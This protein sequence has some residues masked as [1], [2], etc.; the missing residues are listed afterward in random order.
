MNL[1]NI[2]ISS[3]EP[4]QTNALW[5]DA[6]GENNS[7]K[8]YNNG[9][10]TDVSGALFYANADIVDLNNQSVTQVWHLKKG[11]NWWST[12]LDITLEQLEEALGDDGITINAVDNSTAM[13]EN[14]LGWVGNLTTIN[15]AHMYQ[16]QM[17]EDC[18]VELTGQLI[19][20]SSFEIQLHADGGGLNWIG[21]PLNH[22]MDI[23]NALK[24]FKPIEGD[25]IIY[26]SNGK[27][28]KSVY[29]AVRRDGMGG[30]S[31][32]LQTLEPGCGYIYQTTQSRNVT[33][34]YMSYGSV[35]QD[36]QIHDGIMTI[37][38]IMVDNEPKD[39]SDNLI[40]SGAVYT[41]LQNIQQ[42]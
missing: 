5:I 32:T 14:G 29:N 16:I 18:T 38:K 31:G 11:W 10:W 22:K 6:S 13:Y 27:E 9:Q 23:N 20:A 37:T 34:D 40:T 39:G 19:N 4:K 36:I 1:D 28:L 21:Y 41:A 17:A 3:I 33:Y 2:V 24:T 7:I 15:P 12:Y 26:R 30:W 25:V 8:V 35:V 42:P